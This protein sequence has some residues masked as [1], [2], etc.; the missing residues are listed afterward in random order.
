MSTTPETAAIEQVLTELSC[1]DVSDAL[2]RLGINGQCLGIMPLDRSFRIVGQAWTLRYGPVG[3]D[4]GTVGDY[5]DELGPSQVVV[6]DNQGRLDATVWGDLLTSTASRNAVA[7]TVID[8]VC[9]DVDRA[10]SMQYP[11]YSRGNWMRTGKDRVRVEA[12]GAPVSI[13]GVRI[14][15]GDWLLGDGDGIVN[16]PVA[17]IHEVLAAAQEIRDAEEH[18]RQ[19]VEAGKS[20]RQARADYGYHTLQTAR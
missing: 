19:A 1:T 3:E 20:L 13:G 2:D 14:E 10:L 12:V 4:P 15:P 16:I 5:I 7:G 8:G 18:I 17:R 11:I 6:L 9:R